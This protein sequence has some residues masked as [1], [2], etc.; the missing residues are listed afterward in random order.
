MRRRHPYW[1]R[2]WLPRSV[3]RLRGRTFLLRRLFWLR[4]LRR[5]RR[6]MLDMG[7]TLGLGLEL[8]GRNLRLQIGHLVLSR[9]RNPDR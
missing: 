2:W 5:L 9:R 1:L 3:P 7:T 6:I 4:G 8:L